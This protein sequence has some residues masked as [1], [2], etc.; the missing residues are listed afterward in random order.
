MGGLRS[1]HVDKDVRPWLRRTRVRRCGEWRTWEDEVGWQLPLVCVTADGYAARLFS[2]RSRL[3]LPP[4]P[5]L[6][7]SFLAIKDSDGE[8]PLAVFLNTRLE[9]LG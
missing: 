2:G 6:D 8:H 1:A 3:P 5:S 4:V 9:N 7:C